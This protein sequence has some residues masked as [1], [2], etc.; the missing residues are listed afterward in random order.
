MGVEFPINL[1]RS[2]A[3]VP[4]SMPLP[5]FLAL[6]QSVEWR[7]TRAGSS[8]GPYASIHPK[9]L[10]WL[11]SCALINYSTRT[12]TPALGIPVSQ[13]SDTTWSSWLPFTY[14]RTDWSSECANRTGDEKGL[15]T[16]NVSEKT[17]LRTEDIFPPQ[18]SNCK[19]AVTSEVPYQ[20]FDPCA[21][22]CCEIGIHVWNR[23][24]TTH[25][26]IS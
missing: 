21:V 6:P 18:P 11:T 14:I 25:S 7:K 17:K 20:Q 16:H 1:Y 4:F 19:R 15:S 2:H 23:E 26:P 3:D 24:R 22:C 10:L 8:Y 13:K 5:R 12:G 9:G